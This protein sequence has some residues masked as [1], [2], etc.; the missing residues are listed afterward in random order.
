M[1]LV[2]LMGS[3]TRKDGQPYLHVH[4]MLSDPV[5]GKTLAGHLTKLVVG[6]TAE[7]FVRTL[8]GEVGRVVCDKTGLNLMNI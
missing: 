1:E 7:I 8:L 2:S 6:A 5:A 4:A 3:L